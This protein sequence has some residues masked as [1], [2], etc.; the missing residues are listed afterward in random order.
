[1]TVRTRFAPSPT[2]YLHIGSVRTALFNWLF[3]KHSDGKFILRM[4][5]TDRVRSKVEFE[6][7]IIEDLKWLG[8]DWDE[9]PDIGGIFGPYRQ[10][11]RLGLY[12]EYARKLIDRKLAYPCHCSLERLAELKQS[13][14]KAGKPPRYDGRCRDIERS[15]VPEGVNP[16]TRFIVTGKKKIEF[17][18]AVHGHVAF[19]SED[20]GDFVIIGSDNIASYNFAVTIDDALM[21]ITHVIRGEDHL[22]NTPRQILLS[23]SLGF[24][25]PQYLHLPLV[26]SEARTPLSKREHGLSVKNLKEEGYMPEAILNS[27]ARLGWSPGEG[28]LTLEEMKGPFTQ[29]RLSKSPAIF[30]TN[31]LKRFG[32]ALM[33]KTPSERLADLLR[34]FFENVDREKL[35]KAIDAVK[36]SAMTLNGLMALLTPLLREPLCSEEAGKILKGPDTG[37]V[38][39]A[40]GKALADVEELNERTCPAVMEKLRETGLKGKTLLLPIR[41]ALTGQ[42]S[43]IELNKILILLG[44]KNIMERI[45][46]F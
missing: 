31:T 45:K 17:E 24:R 14:L 11:G 15:E 5:D 10:S 1:M 37:V 28:L 25:V 18:D 4:E 9:G 39:S 33:E 40:L 41:A 19:N 42:T 32:R 35:I 12:I 20:I 8:L 26:L 2:G 23:E 38:L 34:P 43:G 13:Q 22:S 27:V 7:A 29:K 21:E 30:D 46:G 44:K 16:A 36:E 3:A 6:K